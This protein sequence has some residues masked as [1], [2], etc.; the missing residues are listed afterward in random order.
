MI[1]GWNI[2]FLGIIAATLTTG[3][4]VPQTIKVWRTKS[5]GDLSLIM[6]LMTWLGIVL[7]IVYGFIIASLA[8][9][10]ANIISLALVSTI[11]YFK[12]RYRPASA[13]G[14]P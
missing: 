7:W 8:L 1:Q 10:Y 4:L 12:L 13:A 3:A 6:Y 2:E 9:L 14:I 11:L 5:A